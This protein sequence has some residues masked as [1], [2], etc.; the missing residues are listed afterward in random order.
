LS[1]RLW[2]RAITGKDGRVRLAVR[3]QPGARRAAV[4]GPY[5]DRLKVAVK[6]P[7]VDGKANA[8]LI[9]LIATLIDVPRS[10]VALDAGHGS[11][12]KRLVVAATLG[13]V[14]AA[15]ERALELP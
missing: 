3:V 2:L 6:A 13:Q 10:A 15:I 1:E 12:D 8:A 14:R 7:P 9:K 11:R 4:L 5:G